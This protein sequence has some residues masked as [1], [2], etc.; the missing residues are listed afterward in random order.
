MVVA[1]LLGTTGLG[2]LDPTMAVVVEDCA[3]EIEVFGGAAELVVVVVEDDAGG[4]TMLVW[5][6]LE[7]GLLV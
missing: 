5:A 6:G 1:L 7:V 2:E 3:A 4:G